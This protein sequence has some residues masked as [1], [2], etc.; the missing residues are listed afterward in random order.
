MGAAV[1]LAWVAGFAG[2]GSPSHATSQRRTWLAL[3]VAV[4]HMTADPL[5]ILR[6]GLTLQLAAFAALVLLR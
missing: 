5:G 4:F 1:L 3:G 6:T 2:T